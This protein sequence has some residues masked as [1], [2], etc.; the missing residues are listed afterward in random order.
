MPASDSVIDTICPITDLTTG[1]AESPEE[2]KARHPD[3]VRMVFD[4][5]LADK[6]RRQDS[7]VEWLLTTEEKYD[8]G[9][10]VLPPIAWH[11]SRFLTGKALRPSRWQTTL[12][13]LHPRDSVAARRRLRRS[14]LHHG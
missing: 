6:A 4:D 9:L 13:R 5:W 10:N 2:V 8:Y 7:P 14:V 12:S 3:A 11:D 1:F